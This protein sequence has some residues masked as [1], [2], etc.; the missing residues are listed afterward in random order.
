MDHVVALAGDDRAPVEVRAAATLLRDTPPQAP[1]LVQ[2]GAPDRRFIEAARRIADW[3]RGETEARL[4]S[5]GTD[6]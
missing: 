3:A 5:A 1:A 6:R 4:S 2:L